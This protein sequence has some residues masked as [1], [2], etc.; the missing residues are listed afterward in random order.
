[1]DTLLF[2]ILGALCLAVRFDFFFLT[3]NVAGHMLYYS[4]TL[5][6]RANF[7]FY[8]LLGRGALCPP[9]PDTAIYKKKVLL[10]RHPVRYMVLPICI[11]LLILPGCQAVNQTAGA[12]PAIQVLTIGTADSG[13]TMYSVGRAIAQVLNE[14]L[15]Y[16]KV[17]IGASNG[18]QTNVE[19]LRDGQIDLALV[20]GEVAYN[21]YMGDEEFQEAPL[22]TLRAIGAVYMSCSNWVTT[23]S[24]GLNYVHDLVN[25]CVAIGPETSSTER[26]A[27]VS[28]AAG[29]ISDENAAL[30]NYGFVAGSEALQNH[31]VDA[32]HYFAGAP[33]QAIQDL[34]AATPCHLLCYTPEELTAILA[35]DNQYMQVTIPAGTYPG[36]TEDV[37]TFGV[38]CI[39]CVSSSLDEELAYTIAGSLWRSAADLAQLQASMGAMK[40]A[41]F[42]C[43]DLPIPL[44][45]GAKRFYNETGLL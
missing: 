40:S 18:S 29:G 26:T 5:A 15:P 12:T 8:R 30:Q 6:L 11:L 31:T 37:E 41:N 13:G 16:T 38:K 10:M 33:V 1:M 17:N 43:K 23:D 25:Q 4:Q 14:S 7:P 28:L 20:S 34:A 27:L 42:V 39:L 19:A 2:I 45:P 21:A 35:Q 9:L 24:A 32:A 22:D 44:H 36:Q 3:G